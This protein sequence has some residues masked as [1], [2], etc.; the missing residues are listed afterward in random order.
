MSNL[1]SQSGER[2]R[3]KSMLEDSHA[4]VLNAILT[5]FFLEYVFYNGSACEGGTI[6]LDNAV[7]CKYQMTV[8]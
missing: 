2:F 3:E 4:N 5:F 1:E 7:C 8:D 6:L